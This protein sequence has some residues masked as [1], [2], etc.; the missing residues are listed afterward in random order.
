MNK[1]IL[2]QQLLRRRIAMNSTDWRDRSALIGQRIL[3]NLPSQPHLSI[4]AYFSIRKEPDLSD[5]WPQLRSR[6]IPFGVPR[7]VGNQLVWHRWEPGN[8]LEVGA[9]GILEPDSTAPVL[10]AKDVGAIL[11]PCVGCDRKG[12][13]I[14]YGGGFYDRLLAQTEWRSIPTIGVTFD[15]GIVEPFEVDEWDQPLNYI[16]TETHWII[17]D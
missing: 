8:R 17:C 6:S 1:A 14:G 15:F 9:F 12:N 2:R 13:R 4:L 10:Q 3:Q 7:C 5:L 11:V 16:C